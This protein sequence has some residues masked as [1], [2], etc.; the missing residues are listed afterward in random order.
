MSTDFGPLLGST[1]ARSDKHHFAV[2]MIGFAGGAARGVG[3]VG[4]SEDVEPI[5]PNSDGME[6]MQSVLPCLLSTRQLVEL[7]IDS[8]GT[9]LLH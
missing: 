8:A 7:C 4:S 1:G 5:V 6:P 9:T 3:E 2:H